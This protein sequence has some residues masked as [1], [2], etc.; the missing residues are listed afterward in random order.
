MSRV[1]SVL[2]GLTLLIAACGGDD[3]DKVVYTGEPTGRIVFTSD[4][5][6]KDDIFIMS[7]DGSD[8]TNLTNNP[9]SSDT[10]PAV[11]HDGERIA[12]LSYRGGPADLWI[13]SVD[14]GEP[15]QLTDHPAIDSRP[16]W[17]PDDTRIAHYSARAQSQG[18]SF[19]WITDIATGG[20]G[21]LLPDRATDPDIGCS[22]VIPTHWPEEDML[23]YQGS[24]PSMSATEVCT[25][26]PSDFTARP[27]ISIPG[28]A[29]FDGVLSPDGA[30]IA[31][32]TD[33]TGNPDIWI[34]NA[35]GSNPLRITFDP[36]R[37]GRPTWS[38][39]GQWLAFA[40]ERVGDSEIYIVRPDGTDL[41]QL[42]DNEF[43][44]DGFP[45]WID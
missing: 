5:D 11:S 34:A 13:M 6:G 43:I 1:I 2:L 39:D 25:V 36:G 37:D 26:N 18:S 9:D 15:E 16:I 14:G 30:R 4:R 41:R 7:A 44:Q 38:P 33:E 27:I 32:T 22:G 20:S 35:D 42:T 29:A 19:L 17:S 12:F 24:R 40:S 10:D 45:T 8:Q 23:I 31:Y 3:D 21:P 28:V